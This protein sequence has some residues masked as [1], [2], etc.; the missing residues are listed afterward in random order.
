MVMILT[1]WNAVSDWRRLMGPVDPDEAKLLSPDSIRAQFGASVLKN[2]VHGSSNIH[3][4]METINQMFE[5][6]VP[7]NPE[8]N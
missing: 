1:K 8:G 4:A 2:A 7:E 6:L 3:E 5:V